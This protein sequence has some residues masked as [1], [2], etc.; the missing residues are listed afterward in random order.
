MTDLR[1]KI[2]DAQARVDGIFVERGRGDAANLLNDLRLTL[3]FLP[4]NVGRYLMQKRAVD[5]NHF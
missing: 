5:L 4:A 2:G 3:T 1:E